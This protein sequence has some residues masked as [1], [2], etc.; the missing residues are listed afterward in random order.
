MNAWQS[1]LLA[2]AIVLGIK[3][4]GYLV[5]ASVASHQRVQKVSDMLTVALLASLVAAQTFA[6]DSEIVLDARVPAVIVAGLLFW[7]RV[8]FI[9]VIVAAAAIAAGLRAFGLSA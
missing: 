1:I 2:S 6:A 5:P 8:P 7:L 4:A 3:L 9:L